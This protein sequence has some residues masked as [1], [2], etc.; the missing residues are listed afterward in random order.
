MLTL[1]RM[2]GQ[3]QYC[4]MVTLNCIFRTTTFL[5]DRFYDTVNLQDLSHIRER[6][7]PQEP[8]EQNEP[9]YDRISITDTVSPADQDYEDVNLTANEQ[10]T[11]GLNIQ[12]GSSSEPHIIEVV[13]NSAYGI[14]I[15]A[16]AAKAKK[17]VNTPNQ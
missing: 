1:K 9:V 2:A 13:P 8:V 4:R 15:R 7:L 17:G 12:P 6:G 3:R 14:N 5:F 10:P 11:S 16:N